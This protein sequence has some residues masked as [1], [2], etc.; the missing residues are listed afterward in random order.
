M[1]HSSKLRGSSR[2]FGLKYDRL[3]SGCQTGNI[4]KAPLP[5]R[6]IADLLI[7]DRGKP[8]SAG[9]SI[10][11]VLY[12]VHGFPP[13]A[14][15]GV[16][17]Y[18]QNLA[19]EM[20]SRGLRVTVLYS[21]TESSGD[22]YSITSN[23]FDGLTLAKFHVP[24]GNLFTQALSLGCLDTAFDSF[25]KSHTFDL[26]HFHHVCDNLSLSMISVAK[27]ADLPVVIT[28]HDFWFIC[29]RAQLFIK[30]NTSVCSGPE[31]P[32]KCA[33]CLFVAERNPGISNADFEQ[34][35][36]ARQSYVR[37]LLIGS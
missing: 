25:L 6:Q 24:R 30:N 23:I 37:N 4:Q 27:K 33:N 5:D 20:I 32:A 31:C 8:D 36:A 2:R 19:K 29:P 21:A 35:I 18:T 9:F 17:V 7:S 11:S 26:V 1:Y 28:L 15:G 12:V 13:A 14:V 3:S 10:K 34:V 22:L 16:E